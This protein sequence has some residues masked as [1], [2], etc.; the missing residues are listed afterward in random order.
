M[1]ALYKQL[2]F[3]LIFSED[4]IVFGIVM[5]VLLTQINL[6]CHDIHTQM[7]FNHKHDLI[8]NKVV[9]KIKEC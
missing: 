4:Q 7:R 5:L 1:Q 8:F 9:G 3:C 2:I 6:C